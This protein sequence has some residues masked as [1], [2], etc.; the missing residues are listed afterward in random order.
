MDE[1]MTI[2]IGADT[3]EFQTA[4]ENLRDLSERCGGRP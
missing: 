1:D 2:S 3:T 4:L